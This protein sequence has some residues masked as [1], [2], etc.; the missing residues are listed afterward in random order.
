M[1]FSRAATLFGTILLTAGAA[2][3]QTRTAK[4]DSPDVK[5][6][7]AYRLSMDAVQRFVTAFKAVMA[8]PAAKKCLESN[9][10]GN[11]ASLD[12]GEKMLNACPGAP[13]DLRAAGIKPREFLIVTGSL[14]ANFMA[15]SMK[16]S[17]MIKEYPTPISP[18]N[19]AFLEQN[20]D[21]LQTLLGPLMSQAK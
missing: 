15:V 12:A 1:T 2:A 20:S 14:F 11:A 8:D 9:P 5:E 7:Y 16:K 17:G 13:G 4:A 21:K 18:E 6:I 3:A 10:P 19:V